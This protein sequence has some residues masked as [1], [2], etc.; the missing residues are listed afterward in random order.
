MADTGTQIRE[1]IRA[2]LETFTHPPRAHVQ[3]FGCQ[4]NFCDGEKYKG[5]LQDLGYELTDTP[6]EADV[7]LFNACAVR[8][9]A[10]SRVIGRLGALKPIYEKNPRLVVGLCGCM[11][12]EE[13]VRALLRKSYP[14]VKLVL[15]AGAMERLPGALAE[16]YRGEKRA[17]SLDF[18]G[19][20][21]ESLPTVRDSGFQAS[22]PVMYGCNNFCTYCI[23]PYV[24]GRERSRTPEAIEQEVR[25]LIGQGYREILLLGQ[26]VNS[27]GRGLDEAISFPALLR[28]LDAIEGDYFIRFMSSHP[29]DATPELIDTMLGSQ[30]IEHHLHLPVQCGSDRVLKEMNRHY[31]LETYLKIVD[32]AREK[33]PDFGFSSDLIV[34]FPTETDADFEG[35]MEIVERVKYDNLYTFIYSRRAG[36]KAADMEFVCTQ[37]QIAARMSRL[38]ARQREISEEFNKRFLGKTVRF[39]AEKRDPETG[40]LLGKT[41]HGLVLE[42]PGTPEDIGRLLAVKVTG[43]KNWALSGEIIREDGH[44]E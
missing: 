10:E 9:H 6:E 29:K 19:L 18:A 13:E 28:R 21:D 40:L 3:S 23:V 20:P 44:A 30:H 4:L 27:Y 37:E 15:G 12:E 33:N 16:I 17:E 39:L 31:T 25:V 8:A 42:A 14:F 7:I 24:R 1:Q 2:V 41:R 11:A 26:N 22:V 35:T 38:L 36:T 5:I 43:V 32:Y 34:G